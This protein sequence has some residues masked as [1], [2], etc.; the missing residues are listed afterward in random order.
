MR[1]R[2]GIRLRTGILGGTFNPVHNG[3]LR[4]AE[5]ARQALSLDR[6]IFMPCAVPPHKGEE[7]LLSSTTRVRMLELAIEGNH[8]FE[9]S[10]MEIKRTGKSYSIETLRELNLLY[11][12]DEEIYFIIGTDSFMEIGIWK[13]YEKLFAMVNFVIVTR[14]GYMEG[15]NEQSPAE[16]LPVDIRGNFCYNPQLHLLEHDSGRVTHFLKTTL[17]D[18]SST[19]IREDLSRRRSIKYLLPVEVERFIE[20]EGLFQ[21]LR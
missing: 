13:D 9:I 3:H 16:L 7:S 12:E 1:D 18:I 2:S 8:F 5:E 20:E 10:D 11:G 14:P 19:R 4:A 15:L 6:I 21:G 17:L